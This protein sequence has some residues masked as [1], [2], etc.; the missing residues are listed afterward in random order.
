MTLRIFVKDI[1]AIDNKDSYERCDFFDT[2]LDTFTSRTN[3]YAHYEFTEGTELSEEA[4]KA[5]Q[6]DS[7]VIR[8]I[9]SHENPLQRMVNNRVIPNHYWE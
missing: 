4:E 6:K 1:K 3:S 9:L 5:I 7:N 2:C 8:A